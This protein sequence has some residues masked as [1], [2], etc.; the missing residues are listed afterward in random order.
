EE[1]PDFVLLLEITP[2]WASALA[3]LNELYPYR[4]I[5]PSMEPAGL[6]ILSHWPLEFEALRDRRGREWPV[7]VVRWDVPGRPI[8]MICAHTKSPQTEHH[9][10]VRNLELRAV[11]EGVR[12][13]EGPV[14]LLGDLNTTS[15]SPYFDDLLHESGLVDSRRGFGVQATWPQMPIS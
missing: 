7:N 11:A 5:S 6:A 15:W 14:V 1:Q 8:T 4:H 9:L 12:R 13:I 10:D 2:Q 3:E